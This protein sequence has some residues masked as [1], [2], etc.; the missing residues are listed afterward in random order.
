MLHADNH[1]AAHHQVV[2]HRQIAA[3][4]ESRVINSSARIPFCAAQSRGYQ[5]S[6]IISEV[7]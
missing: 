5:T 6:Q 3:I 7:M 1:K 4:S 2:P